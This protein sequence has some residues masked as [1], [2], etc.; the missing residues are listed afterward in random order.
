M[1][2]FK[3]FADVISRIKNKLTK[4]ISTSQDDSWAVDVEYSGIPIIEQMQDKIIGA[5]K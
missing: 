4:K 3:G 5:I 1:H 2:G